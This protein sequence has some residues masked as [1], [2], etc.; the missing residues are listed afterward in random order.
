M[1]RQRA[2]RGVGYGNESRAGVFAAAKEENTFMF[3]ETSL[4][5]SNERDNNELALEIK[6]YVEQIS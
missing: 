3:A 2:R 1:W 5:H 6:N 4:L